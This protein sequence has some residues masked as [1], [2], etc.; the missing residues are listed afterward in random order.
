MLGVSIWII[1]DNGNDRF[2]KFKLL[3]SIIR[4]ARIPK[5][6]HVSFSRRNNHLLMFRQLIL[7]DEFPMCHNL[8][9]FSPIKTAIKNWVIIGWRL[10]SCGKLNQLNN[11][12]INT[13]LKL[14]LHSRNSI[15]VSIIQFHDQLFGWKTTNRT[16]HFFHFEFPRV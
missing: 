15:S 8:Y 9:A 3:I 7:F 11:N 12:S 10:F 16:I 1:D 14:H 6:T 5:Q 2:F 13:K 4:I